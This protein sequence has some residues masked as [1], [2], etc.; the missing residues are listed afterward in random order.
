M[1]F[2]DIIL[3]MI[4]ISNYEL[5]FKRTNFANKRSIFHL[6]SQNVLYA[7]IGCAFLKQ[8]YYLERL[9]KILK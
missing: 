6:T 4:Q 7:K 3:I 5:M 2:G 1:Y 9:V 8:K